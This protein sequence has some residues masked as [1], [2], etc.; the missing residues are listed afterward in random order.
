MTLDIILVRSKAT[1]PELDSEVFLLKLDPQNDKGF[2]KFSPLL[3]IQ[4]FSP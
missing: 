3:Y 4:F 1:H 2:F